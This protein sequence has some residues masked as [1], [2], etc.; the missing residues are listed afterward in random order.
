MLNIVWIRKLLSIGRRVG[1][2]LDVKCCVD[3]K[4]V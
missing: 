2:E 3:R 4:V 1:D